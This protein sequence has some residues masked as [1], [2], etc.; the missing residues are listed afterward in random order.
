IP[1]DVKS[2]HIAWSLKLSIWEDHETP[3]FNYYRSDDDTYTVACIRE[4]LAEFGESLA[5]SLE[6]KLMQISL[7]EL[8]DLNLLLPPHDEDV[9]EDFVVGERK[10]KAALIIPVIFILVLAMGYYLIGVKKIFQ[11]SSAPVEMAVQDS[12]PA[13]EEPS[14]E[15]IEQQTPPV[16]EEPQVADTKPAPASQQP[17]AVTAASGQAPFTGIFSI[18]HNSADIYHLSFTGETIRCKISSSARNKAD[19]VTGMLSSSGLTAG[20]KKQF[21]SAEDGKHI[22]IITASILD[23]HINGFLH[24]EV[25]AV[26]NILNKSGFKT[27]SRNR[28]YDI[29]N[30]SSQTVSSILKL[31]D[32]NRILLYRIRIS[33]VDPDQYVLTLEY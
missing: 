18:F 32:K 20:I 15:E 1:S 25:Q 8:P 13:V 26:K 10:S 23:R 3:R 28:K 7:A 22:A 21:S 24:P 16:E 27:D 29:F 9:D 6:A 2:E 19:V 17:K 5:D 4:S 11:R 12:I 31:I 30:G 33:Q 14:A